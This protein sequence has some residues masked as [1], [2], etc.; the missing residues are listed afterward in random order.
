MIAVLDDAP[1]PP[2]A[3]PRVR[4][5]AVRLRP[6]GDDPG[7]PWSSTSGRVK[8]NNTLHP[9]HP[10]SVGKTVA[11]LGA[12]FTTGVAIFSFVGVYDGE[13]FWD[14]MVQHLILIM[15]AAPLFAIASPLD[16]AW[17]STSG[18]AH[19]VVTEA[20]RS[21]VAKVL[22]HPVTAF[23]LYA[24]IIPVSHLTSWYNLTLEHESVHNAEHLAFLVVGY[25]FWRQIFGSDPNSYRLHPALQFFYLFMAIPI[26][27][28]TGLSLAG[29][30]PRALPGIL[31]HAPDLGPLLRHRP[32][33]GRR[34]HVGRRRHA[35]AVADDP[36]GT[37]LDAHGRAQGGPGRSRVGCGAG[38]RLQSFTRFFWAVIP[39]SRRLSRTV[40]RRSPPRARRSAGRCSPRAEAPAIHRLR[41]PPRA[42]WRTGRYPNVPLISSSGA[43]TSLAAYRGKD[44]VMAPFLSL[45]QDE[46]PLVT[47]AFI[48]LQR[49]VRAA[50]LGSKVVFMEI[51]VDPGRDTPARLA[52]YSKEFGADW[53]LATGTPA[54]LDALWKFLGVSVQIVPEEQPAKIDWYTGTPLTY[55]VDHTDGYFLI[56]ASGHERFSDSNPPNLNGHL[57]KK[58]T[59]LLNG[60][61]LQNLD[62]QG[63]P[64]W[65][66]SD[67]LSSISWLVGQN[68]PGDREHL[69][70]PDRLRRTSGGGATPNGR[71]RD[72]RPGSIER[73]IANHG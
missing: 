55:D 53:V 14:H 40:G 52:A 61:G 37:A 70:A 32:P 65:T 68:I 20:L 72:H 1:L 9:R 26:D 67:A 34:H 16:L 17:R 12:L 41:R 38:S 49:D 48:A 13:L 44:I 23:V 46:C 69:M 10:W 24:V 73:G 57:D 29:G 6:G 59:N 39:W 7:R 28:F 5:D 27:T 50:G 42:S 66:L 64:N 54:N 62:H 4:L 58:L 36:R 60:G 3:G 51:T 35:H 8:R 15:V 19:I 71:M 47:G 43:P 33:R 21:R 18:T 63:N 22:G 25:L 45:C 56:D 30:Q 31:R 11:W 2:L